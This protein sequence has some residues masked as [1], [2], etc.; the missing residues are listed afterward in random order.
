MVGDPG[1]R[2]LTEQLVVQHRADAQA[3]PGKATPKT[4]QEAAQHGV[5][6]AGGPLPFAVKFSACSGITTYLM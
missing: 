6:G 1:K 3:V 5:S 4:V 2:T